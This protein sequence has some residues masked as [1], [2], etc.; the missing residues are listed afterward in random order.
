[1][2]QELIDEG[3]N[4]PSRTTPFAALLLMHTVWIPDRLNHRM[5]LAF[6]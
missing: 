6:K 2:N 4:Y 1:V 3:K 5:D